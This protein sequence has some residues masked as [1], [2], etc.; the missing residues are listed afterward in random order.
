MSLRH[1]ESVR[2]V[3]VPRWRRKDYKTTTE[4]EKHGDTPNQTKPKKGFIESHT[5]R[6]G[7]DGE[8]K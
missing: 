7:L 4:K 8:R 6:D 2:C 3:S 5:W 1:Q